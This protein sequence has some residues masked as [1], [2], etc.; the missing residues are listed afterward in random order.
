[1]VKVEN[2]RTGDGNRGMTPFIEGQGLLHVALNGGARSL[3]VDRH[4]PNWSRVIEACAK[5]ADAVLAELGL[6]DLQAAD[7]RA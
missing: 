4:S 6:A 1:M 5:W 7:P 3:A 2:P